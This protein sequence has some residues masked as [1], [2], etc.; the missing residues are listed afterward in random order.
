ME[1]A[2]HLRL[3]HLHVRYGVKDV[4]RDVSMEVGAGEIVSLLG[5]NG[6]GKSSILRA[7]AGVLRPSKGS[8]ILGDRDIT[9]ISPRAR[10]ELG[11]GY[12][13]QGG[14][15]FPSLSVADNL[16]VGGMAL[17]ASV[18]DERITEIV[19]IFPPLA[20]RFEERAGLLSGGL[21]QMLAL[22]IV[23]VG[24][25]RLLLLD[26][27]SA[28]LAPALV[29]GLMD[30]VASI[31]IRRRCSILLVEQNVRAALA[32]THRAYLLKEG[33]VVAEGMPDVLQ[34]R[35]TVEAVFFG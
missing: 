5:P 11:I 31:N 20:R 28:G 13:L 19:D 15:I 7:V 18:Q 32:I 22:G 29:A 26:E 34:A 12:L 2:L 25:P 6:A 27:P 17:P 33:A 9:A 21:R 30:T 1:N 24:H 16:K 35:K 3:D 8:I 4:V 14:Q 10:V 23:L